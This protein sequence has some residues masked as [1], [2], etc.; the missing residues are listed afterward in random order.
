MAKTP[1]IGEDPYHRPIY[2]EK[3]DGIMQF[4]G[5]GAYKCENCGQVELDDWGKVRE[6]LYK[7][8]KANALDIEKDIGVDRRAINRM[9]RE[10]KIETVSKSSLLRCEKCGKQIRSGHMCEACEKLYHRQ[11]EEQARKERQERK[12]IH[13]VSARLHGDEGRIRYSGFSNKQ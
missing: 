10:G 1:R 7:H 5:C 12:N 13:G 11:I 4:I 9:L 3:C 2:C 8:V 6:Y